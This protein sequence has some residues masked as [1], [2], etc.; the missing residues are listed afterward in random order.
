MG[1]LFN[2]PFCSC[3]FCSKLD[4]ERHIEV[5]GRNKA[6]HVRKMRKVSFE[7][8]NGIYEAHGGADKQLRILARI[9]ESLRGD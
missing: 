5:F 9:I 3:V 8:E 1:E 7:V 2:C 6:K 4:L